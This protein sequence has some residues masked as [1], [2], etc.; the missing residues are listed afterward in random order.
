MCESSSPVLR[1]T[2]DRGSSRLCWPRATASSRHELG[3]GADGSL[4]VVALD[5]GNPPATMQRSQ[6]PAP[7]PSSTTSC[8]GPPTGN[9]GPP[10][11]PPP[12]PPRRPPKR[13]GVRGIAYLGGFVPED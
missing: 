1:G 3:R 13:T 2:W 10:T 7:S 9:P 5:A 6:G 11:T 12:Q 8:R 4:D